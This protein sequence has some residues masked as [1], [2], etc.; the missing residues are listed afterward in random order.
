MNLSMKFMAEV[1]RYFGAGL[2][3]LVLFEHNDVTIPI[4]LHGKFG[5]DSK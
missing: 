5:F 4:P 1:S 3:V 2:V